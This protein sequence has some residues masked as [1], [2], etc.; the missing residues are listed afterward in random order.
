M[1]LHLDHTV[2]LVYHSFGSNNLKRKSEP[3]PTP[4]QHL[5]VAEQILASPA[6]PEINRA[7]SEQNEAVLSAYFFGHIAPDVQVV[8]RQ[9]REATH[10]FTLPPINDGPAYLRMLATHPRLAQ[11]STLPAVQVAFLV[12]Y[13]SHLLLDEYWVREIFYPFFGPRQTW[14]DRR[15]RVLL[16]NV[17]RAWLDRRDLSRLRDGIGELL[18][19]VKPNGW[20]PFATDED[21]VRWRDLVA[22]QFAP[23]AEIRTVEIFANRSR[24]PDVQFLALLEPTVMQERIFGRISLANLDRFHDRAVLHIHDLVV[25]YLSDCAGGESV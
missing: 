6:L 17:L 11:P 2:G 10:F 24:V 4:V 18:C 25:R 9:P 20:L 15:E 13:I 7:Q 1:P 5:T 3:L 14:G 12:G 21:L 22:D 16:H 19:Q 23:G 8:S